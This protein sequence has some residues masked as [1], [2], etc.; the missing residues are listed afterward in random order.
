MAILGYPISILPISHCNMCNVWVKNK[1]YEWCV[2]FDFA[3]R[4]E[5]HKKLRGG[6]EFIT[7]IPKTASGKLLRRTLRERAKHQDKL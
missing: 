7:E 2:V 6:V 3:D 5:V 4:C 1:Q